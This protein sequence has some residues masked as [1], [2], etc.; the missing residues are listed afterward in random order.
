MVASPLYH[1]KHTL[2]ERYLFDAV[3]KPL[4]VGGVTLSNRIV[5]P[6]FQTNYATADGFVTDRLLRFYR[7]IAQGG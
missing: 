6:P 7:E 3:F 1:Y 2:R 5:F 4:T